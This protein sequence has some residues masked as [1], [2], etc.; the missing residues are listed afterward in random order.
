[1]ECPLPG[2]PCVPPS[3]ML[4]EDCLTNQDNPWSCHWGAKKSAFLFLISTCSDIHSLEKYATQD[5]SG[6]QQT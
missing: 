4:P 1:M 2:P 3:V 6:I 5:E